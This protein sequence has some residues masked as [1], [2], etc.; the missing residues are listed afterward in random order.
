MLSDFMA[1]C[2]KETGRLSIV[3][4]NILDILNISHSKKYPMILWRKKYSIFMTNSVYG[5]VG[6][7]WWPSGGPFAAGI[8]SGVGHSVLCGM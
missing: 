6:H 4:V 1:V 5:R 2:K 3:V 8:F 7:I